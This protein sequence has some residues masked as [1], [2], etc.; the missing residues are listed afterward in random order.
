MLKVDIGWNFATLED[1][2]TF[3]HPSNS[4][5]ALQMADIGLD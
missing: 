4:C 1:E 5:R 3:D 2:N